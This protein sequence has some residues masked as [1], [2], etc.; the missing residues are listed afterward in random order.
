MSPMP[1]T[2]VTR[3][4]LSFYLFIAIAIVGLSAALEPFFYGNDKQLPPS[5]KEIK[6]QLEGLSGE[7]RAH[8]VAQ[9]TT[10]QPQV[11]PL[12]S[13]AFSEETLTDLLHGE[14]IALFYQNTVQLYARADD[15]SLYEFTFP[16][17][18]DAPPATLYSLVFFIA[19]GLVVALWIWPLWRDLSNIT[20]GIKTVDPDGSIPPIV[21]PKRSVVA[22]IA[23]ALNALSQQVSE[24][25]ARH[26]EMTGAVAHELRTPLARLKFTLGSNDT[27][28]QES[29]FAM[30]EDVNE[31]ERMVQEMLDYLRHDGKPPEL[32]VSHIPVAAL[33]EN[34][35]QRVKPQSKNINIHILPTSLNVMGDGYF[36]ERA[37]EN[38]VLNAVRHAHSKVLLSAEQSKGFVVIHVEDDGPGVAPQDAEKIF[39]PFFRPDSARSRERGGAGLGL[40]IV[41]RIQ[42]W[43]HGYCSVK[44]SKLGGANFSISY[45][46]RT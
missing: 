42:S 5:A 39:T 12:S 27:P 45:P 38:I 41:K 43:H 10:H 17:G 3:L 34:I 14:V 24:L 29:W 7:A 28:D 11:L 35:V 18:S 13:L 31:L 46:T 21:V 36:I 1:G 32:N 33:L 22:P 15:E 26:K 44:K 9:L 23:S 40:A 16:A 25:L 30:R 20:K 8:V 2:S 19:L 37:I 4:F 6:T